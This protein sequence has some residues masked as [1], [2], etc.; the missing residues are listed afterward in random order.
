VLLSL[1][2]LPLGQLVAWAAWP[3]IV[4]TI[5]MV[6][7]FDRIPHGTLFLGNFSIWFM[8][9]FYALLLFVTFQSPR[10]NTWFQAMKRD[11]LRIPLGTG[12]VLLALALLLVWRA[13][14]AIPDQYLHITFLEVG[15]A[16][17]IF[18]R[19][20][21]GKSILI[22]GGPSVTTLSDELG[23][24]LPTFNRKLDW[25]VVAS[26]EEEDVAALPRVVERYPP[27]AV[28]WSGNTQASFSSG[29]LSQYLAVSEI[30]VTNAE[31]DQQLELGDGANLRVLTTGPRGAVLLLEWKN[32]RLL[33]PVGMSLEALK[34]LRNGA[35]VGPV[36]VLLLADSGYAVSN[37][38][39]WITNLNPELVLLDVSAADEN[40]MPDSDVLESVKDFELLRTDQNGWV[41]VTTDGTQMWVKVERK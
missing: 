12:L 29:V 18:I 30:P 19:T 7:L 10:V 5:R 1:V 28:L 24:R 6:E 23:R 2:S 21:T 41:E 20:P 35:R 38:P 9:L 26:T 15:S 32:F 17:A 8:I 13:A 16:D 33:L 27:D 39:E 37:P 3:F 4:Y 14:V 40:G 22:N 31:P 36:N 11:Q 25:L 34:E